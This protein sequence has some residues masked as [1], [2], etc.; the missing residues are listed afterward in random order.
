M[1]DKASSTNTK[2]TPTEKKRVVPRKQLPSVAYLLKHGNP[3]TAH[4]PKTW[5]EIVGYPL[6]LAIVFGISLL[7]FHHAPHHLSK[8]HHKFTL[9]RKEEQQPN[10]QVMETNSETTPPDVV[11]DA[12]GMPEAPEV[13]DNPEQVHELPKVPDTPEIPKPEL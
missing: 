3:E 6:A 12:P 1:S 4:L 5:C 9:P 2:D 7:L 8:K 11:P 13:P 10:I